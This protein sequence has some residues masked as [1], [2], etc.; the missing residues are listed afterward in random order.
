MCLL[1]IV[2]CVLDILLIIIRRRKFITRTES[3]MK[4][5]SEARAVARWPDE[6]C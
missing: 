4:Y 2:M 5:K 6:V 1:F 3:N